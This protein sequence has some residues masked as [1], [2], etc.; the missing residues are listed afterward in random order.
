MHTIVYCLIYFECQLPPSKWEGL[1]ILED[2]QIRE[3][4]VIK[5]LILRTGVNFLG[6]A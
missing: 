2:N 4:G 3:W 5:P 6:R 1:N